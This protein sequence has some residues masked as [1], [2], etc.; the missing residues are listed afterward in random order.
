MLQEHIAFNV[1]DPAGVAGWYCEHL[2]LKKV[3]GSGD[4]Y[5]IADD[6]GHG[7]LEIY[8]HPEAPVP[9]YAS[10]NPMALHVAFVSADVD[11][12]E[13]STGQLTTNMQYMLVIGGPH[14]SVTR[15]DRIKMPRQ[16]RRLHSYLHFQS[17]FG[18]YASLA[19][20]HDLQHDT[21]SKSTDAGRLGRGSTSETHGA[22]IWAHSPRGGVSERGSSN[23]RWLPDGSVALRDRVRVLACPAP[24]SPAGSGIPYTIITNCGLSTYGLRLVW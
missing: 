3:A 20:S 7:I 8:K 21:V 6:S 4:A 2:G 13:G 11:A 23:G 16:R 1:A 10:M 19:T 12:D 15:R 17:E 5:F 9:D 14:R 22:G 18:P 24:I